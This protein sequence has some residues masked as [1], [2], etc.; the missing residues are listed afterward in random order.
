MWWTELPGL[1]KLM[2]ELAQARA[3]WEAQDR[4]VADMEAALFDSPAGMACKA[5]RKALGPLADRMNIASAV[6]K[7]QALEDFKRDGEKKIFVGVNV[8]MFKRV[9]LNEAAVKAWAIEHMPNLLVLDR[10]AVDSVALTGVF[11]EDLAIVETEPQVQIA[12]DLSA[13]L[14]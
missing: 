5:A 10:K 7:A 3:E 6:A 9:R 4:L 2:G 12:G 13:Y 1:P 14:S 11:S 8:K